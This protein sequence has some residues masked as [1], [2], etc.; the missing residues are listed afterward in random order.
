MKQI[1]IT[2]LELSF[3][4]IETFNQCPRKYYYNYVLR[5][6]KKTW[7]WLVL[8]TFVHLALEKFHKYVIYCKRRDLIPDY[9]ELMKHAYLS[10][11]KVYKN[12]SYDKSKKKIDSNFIVTD[13]QLEQSKEILSNYLRKITKDFPNTQFVEKGFRLKIGNY[14]MRGYIDR[15]DKLADNFYEVI[16]YK[17]SSKAADVDKTYQVA[18]YAYALRILLNQ[19]VK[20]KT[21]LD[22]IKLGKESK[23]TYKDSQKELVEK[24]IQKA[25]DTI[26]EAIA[27][28]KEEKDWIPKDNN[29][30]KFCDFQERCYAQR[31]KNQFQS[32]FIL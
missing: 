4:A 11:K 32:D 27:N 12:K 3:S 2:P 15:I 17:T 29:F 10:A 5:L 13:K 23:G 21:K 20:I 1:A 9:K 7:P 30:C 28:L 18:I 24:Y 14:I 22:F 26:S 16:D 19:D 6:P 31:G 25:G 8:G